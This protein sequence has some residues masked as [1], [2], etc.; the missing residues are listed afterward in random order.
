MN[1]AQVFILPSTWNAH[2]TGVTWKVKRGPEAAIVDAVG[3]R[4]MYA[5]M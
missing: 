5:F 4:T 1:E 3:D 2:D